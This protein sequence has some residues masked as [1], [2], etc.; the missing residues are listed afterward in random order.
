[1]ENN[2]S[3]CTS[4]PIPEVTV[5]P[6]TEPVAE[7]IPQLDT[8]LNDRGF[9]GAVLLLFKVKFDDNDSKSVSILK[10]TLSEIYYSFELE[11]IRKNIKEDEKLAGIIRNIHNILTDESTT[12][13]L[14]L[15]RILNFIMNYDRP[16]D[17]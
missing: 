3:S 5:S 14:K 10:Q 4:E 6:V 7:P 1:M 9:I 16:F 11:P 17:I 8:N 2:C 12:D 15:N 13:S